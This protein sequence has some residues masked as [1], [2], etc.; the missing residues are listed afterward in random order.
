MSNAPVHEPPPVGMP[1]RRRRRWL[2]LG[3]A[4]AV[5][6]V[7]AMLGVYAYVEYAAE[8]E[9]RDAIAEA[10]RLDPGWRFADLEAARPDVVDA[11]NSAL[12]IAA[13]SAK[14]PRTF[15]AARP[16]GGPT[17][18]ERLQD[19]PPDQGLTDAELI[20]VRA[21]LAKAAAAL[22]AARDVAD[23]PCG[24]WAVAWDTQF[25][26]ATLVPHI[27]QTRRVT[28]LLVLD[29]AAALANGKPDSAVRSCRAAL[30]AGRS[31][32]GEPAPISQMVRMACVVDGVR[33]LERVL[34]QG[35]AS[36]APLQA[37]QQLLAE[38]AAA[39]TL[40]IRARA[41]RA[42]WFQALEA[43]RTGHYNRAAFRLMPSHLGERFDIQVERVLAHGAAAPF[44][45]YNTA[46]VEAV[47]LPAQEQEDCLRTLAMP[48]QKLPPLLEGLTIAAPGNRKNEWAS[49]ALHFHRTQA[50][51]LCAE[52]AM[53][54]ER[55]RLAEQRWP[56]DLQALVPRYVAAVPSDPFDRRPLRL[57][58][59]PDG[60]VI[61][62]VGADRSDDGG[63]LDRRNPESANIDIGFQ[64]WDADRRGLPPAKT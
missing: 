43:M 18:L 34:A 50:F 62:S 27:D 58:R 55:Y 8:G 60:I 44:L 7:A 36:V 3:T 32:D 31:L 17:I 48:T 19:R 11:E 2:L 52:T 28:Y 24:R 20:E 30:N 37:V 5:V 38:E 61:Y 13:A 4:A 16:D 15:L 10:D 14:I 39:P 42:M 64:L 45:R 22:S 40:L 9:L 25:L 41:D 29:A 47:K 49:T 59:L 51:L 12:L 21:E 35:E 1:R 56:A 57:H 23:R 46:V 6:I 54:A 33:A 63:K 26:I 53:A